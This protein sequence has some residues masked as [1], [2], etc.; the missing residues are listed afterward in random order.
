MNEFYDRFLSNYFTEEKESHASSKITNSNVIGWSELFD[1]YN[2]CSFNSGMY[3]LIQNENLEDW[4]ALIYSVFPAFEGRITPFGYDWLGRFFCLDN[5]RKNNDQQLVLLFSP[6]SNEVLEIPATFY[7]FHNIVLVDQSEPA[8]ECNLF[9]QFIKQKNISRIAL[10]Q[11]AE[12]SVPMYLGGSFTISNMDL[13]ELKFYW[14]VTSQI[15][16][17]IE[18]YPVGTPI[19]EVKLVKSH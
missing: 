1:H 11:C 14:E 9:R 15:I 10:D 2:G 18:S 6:F 17:Q 3:R 5:D 16:S 7:E 4:G 8:L 19:H 12:L 13:V